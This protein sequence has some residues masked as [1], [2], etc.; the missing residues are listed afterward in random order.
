LLDHARRLQGQ[1]KHQDR[2]IGTVTNL[3]ASGEFGFL[4]SDDGREVYFH[5]N[6]VIDG[7]FS[8]LTVGSRAI[9]AEEI[10][11]QGPQASTVKLLGKHGLQTCRD[12]ASR[13]RAGR[14]TS[15]WI[16]G[17]ADKMP[18][19][20]ITAGSIEA[21]RWR[22]D[23]VLWPT[24]CRHGDGLCVGGSM[25]SPCAGSISPLTGSREMANASPFSGSA[26]A[27]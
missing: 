9:F 4:Q 11:E 12:P 10:G 14:C 17:L 24:L 1:V 7:G 13:L 21:I 19:R 20:R 2:P 22:Y 8:R 5:R 6:G 15:R 3:D 18:L 16:S 26:D 27:A 23:A 25:P